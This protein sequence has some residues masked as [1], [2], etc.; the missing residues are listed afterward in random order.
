MSV[1]PAGAVAETAL[2]A[3]P[4]QV[5]SGVVR[6]VA[7]AGGWGVP[8][9]LRVSGVEPVAALAG[10]G[11]EI[12]A[13]Q[14]SPWLL[15]ALYEA[16]LAPEARFAGAHYTPVDV[17]ARLTALVLPRVAVHGDR[18]TGTPLGG[19]CEG[20]PGPLPRVWDPACGGGAFLLAAADALLAAG[21]RADQIVSEQLWGTDIDPGAVA[22]TEAALCWWAHRHGVDAAPG[23]HLVVADPLV[24]EPLTAGEGSADAMDSPLVRAA[25][26]GFDVVL[27]NPPF[28]GQLTGPS[29]R[30]A[31]ATTA[32]R[33]RWG[34]EVVGP[35]TDAASLFLVA[36][37]R[38]LAP[39]G[40]LLMVQP[41]SVLAARDAAGARA[42]AT[43]VAELTGLWVADEPVFDAAVDVCAV[44]LERPDVPSGP[45]RRDTRVN[46]SSADGSSTCALPIAACP[47]PVV[48]R[49]KGQAVDVLPSATVG[50]LVGRSRATDRGGPWSGYALAALGVPDPPARFAGRLGSISTAR[51]GFRDEY[52]GLVGHVVEAAL[53]DG[54][55][56]GRGGGRGCHETPDGSAHDLPAG[57]SPLITSVPAELAPLVT[58][59]LVDP[60]RCAWGARPV[61]FARIRYQRPAVDRASLAAVGGRA[62]AWVQALSVP[63]VV[64]ATQT[65]VGE[66]AVDE[67]GRWVA[68][69]PTIAVVAEPHWLWSIAAVVCSPVGTIA[70][71][72]ATAGTARS[73]GAIRHG[74]A[75]VAGLPLPVDLDAWS[76]GAG[77]LRRL[78]RPAFLAA[79]SAAYGLPAT[80][81]VDDWWTS[82]APWP[83]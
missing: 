56:H 36:G 3:D 50:S 16:A 40:R 59:G 61:T 53:L 68:S 23:P 76:A 12:E 34:T 55:G 37:A 69:T 4:L 72:A 38:G 14:A 67:A 31:E 7:E 1:A 81:E 43:D 75:S 42:V 29:V 27:G 82:R 9:D 28:Q 49:W 83:P 32:L 8:Q 24:D 2:G 80:A 41:M 15:G 58:S 26:H 20:R 54:D 74:V 21:G 63:K 33:A 10:S 17:A 18:P 57:L 64:V 62:A 51:A 71:L 77:A 13:G 78:D 60:G 30:T 5:A 65:R 70:A 35:Y 11:V 25:A 52:Y 39:G 46:G 6:L 73:G 44:L 48:R 66:A 79:M 45:Q 47:A 19:R 22:V